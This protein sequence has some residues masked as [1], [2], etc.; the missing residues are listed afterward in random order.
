[1]GGGL[2]RNAF[3]NGY[4]LD[5]ITDSEYTRL[6]GAVTGSSREKLL[7]IWTNKLEYRGVKVAPNPDSSTLYFLP[8]GDLPYSRLKLFVDAENDKRNAYFAA[9]KQKKSKNEDAENL[10]AKA[11]SVIPT[12]ANAQA[13][14]F[15]ANIDGSQKKK[16][17]I[18]QI[19]PG[20]SLS[21]L[22][23]L[24]E[25]LL[26][27]NT[28]MAVVSYMKAALTCQDGETP[29]VYRYWTTVF[30]SALQMNYLSALEIFAGFQRF[31]QAFRGDKLIGGD[32]PAARNYFWVIGRL[33]RLQH[34][35]HTARTTPEKLNTIE[36]NNELNAVE[37][38]QLTSKGV[39][40]MMKLACPPSLELVGEIYE[41]LWDNQKN[42]L[43]AFVK[44]AWQGVPDDDF[45]I[46][47]R[48]ALTGILLNELTYAVTKAGRSF[49]VTQGRHPSTLRGEHL[50]SIF[51]K[52]I[53]LL[54]NL[55]E[56][57]RFNCNALPFINSCLAES[58]KTTFNSGL[59]MGL[60]FFHKN[61]EKE[62]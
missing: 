29:S 43:D 39:F 4:K 52:G 48:G 37:Q 18:Q 12:P 22:S 34:L 13:T 1:M 8:E 14:L 3:G 2:G 57:R 27:A 53:G 20:I 41:Q 51:T 58:R 60:V 47:V 31:C 38:Y 59:I 9:K 62:A 24:N 40:G 36:F 17:I 19:F 35:I 45:A 44:Q 54:M 15:L 21:Y 7:E 16:L 11:P 56:Q 5:E 46:F 49:S 6:M 23:C 42:K 10:N 28:Q 55:D 26:T 25:E 32:T 30:T 50:I 33:R 61:S